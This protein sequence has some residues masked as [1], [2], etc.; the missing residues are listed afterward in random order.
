MHRCH[1]RAP[2]AWAMENNDDNTAII[3]QWE[4]LEAQFVPKQDAKSLMK[5]I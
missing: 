4:Q 1:T 3:M 5:I 2:A